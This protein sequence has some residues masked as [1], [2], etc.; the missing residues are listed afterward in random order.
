MGAAASRRCE[1]PVAMYRKFATE[2]WPGGRQW[3]ENALVVNRGLLARW[4]WVA[5]VE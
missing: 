3:D 4:R 5:Y 2:I 1:K